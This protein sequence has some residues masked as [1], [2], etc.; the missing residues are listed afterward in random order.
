LASRP[1]F[2][3]WDDPSYLAYFTNPPEYGRNWWRF[4]IEEPGWTLL[5]STLRGAMHP[6]AAYRWVRFFS[7]LL[8]FLGANRLIGG[9]WLSV[10]RGSWLFLLGF[11]LDEQVGARGYISAIR[12]GLADSV[13][14]FLMA[15]RAPAAVSVLGAASLHSAMLVVAPVATFLRSLLRNKW[16]A[17]GAAAIVVIY[18]IL[19][20]LGLAP[21]PLESAQLGRREDT[22]A[23]ASGLNFLGFFGVAFK[24]APF[25]WLLR[26]SQSPW[27][28]ITLIMAPMMM[29]LSIANPGFLRLVL[30]VDLF[31]LMAMCTAPDTGETRVGIA[32]WL[33]VNVFFELWAGR[34]ADPRDSWLGLWSL[35]LQL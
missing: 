18:A 6:E 3:T 16:L 17:V 15:L 34:H 12:Q 13:F 32:F 1:L 2:A 28:A 11:F 26:K 21:S 33:A 7:P 14:I 25:L 35:A 23:F 4:L 31:A 20:S 8:L 22:Y 5:T 27:Y 9:R 29:A 24:Y 19:L 10:T 30:T